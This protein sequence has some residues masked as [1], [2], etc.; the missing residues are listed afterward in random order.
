MICSRHRGVAVAAAVVVVLA[1]DACGSSAAHSSVS[2]T[3][4]GT[5]VA[6]A[7]N[8][9]TSTT[10]TSASNGD[11]VCTFPTWTNEV[12]LVTD[13]LAQASALNSSITAD[14]PMVITASGGWAYTGN[15][16]GDTGEGGVAQ[17]VMTARTYQSTYGTPDLYYYLGQTLQEAG[18]EVAKGGASTM[19]SAADL[20]SVAPCIAGYGSCTTTNMVLIA[21]GGGGQGNSGSACLGGNGGAGGMVTA[22]DASPATASGSDGHD[23]NC[24]GG[25]GGHGGNEGKGGG[26]GDGGDGA[27]GHAG[28]SGDDGIGGVGGPI[29]DSNGHDTLVEWINATDHYQYGVMAFVGTTAGAGGEGEWRGQSSTVDGAGGG[30]G[31]GF[32]GGGGGG[33][34]GGLDPGGGGAG[35]GSWAA[36]CTILTTTAPTFTPTESSAVQVTFIPG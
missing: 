22:T 11:V 35:G 26:G 15:A 36:G 10:C 31:G 18:D 32:G 29:H 9:D 14:S 34:G 8:A 25:H 23:S 20:N 24:S 33:G 21:G 16:K 5:G 3:T 27:D 2:A 4:S 17:T 1:L 28:L 7:H 13:P 30:G 12:D 6:Q 19:V